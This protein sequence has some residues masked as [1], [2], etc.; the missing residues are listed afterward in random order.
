MKW[1]DQSTDVG[2][3]A[4]HVKFTQFG[5][6]DE[7]DELQEGSERR[8]RY[9]TDLL[10]AVKGYSRIGVPVP[11]LLGSEHKAPD[12]RVTTQETYLTL[13]D[14]VLV[15][16]YTRIPIGDGMR[17]DWGEI[18]VYSNTHPLDTVTGNLARIVEGV[19]VPSG[20]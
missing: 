20:E 19:P 12:G 5:F 8:L 6:L 9:L 4:K 14:E 15:L 18:T 10:L 7:L 3:V 1:I 11:V 16:K 13:D 2:D 17:V